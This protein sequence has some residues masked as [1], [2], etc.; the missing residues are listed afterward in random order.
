MAYS[1]TSSSRDEQAPIDALTFTRLSKGLNIRD[2]DW[3]SAMVELESIS[4]AEL[5]ERLAADYPSDLLVPSAYDKADRSRRPER[6]FVSLFARRNLIEAL[7]DTQNEYNVVN[8]HLGLLTPEEWLS[9]EADAPDLSPIEVPKGSVVTAMI[10]DGIGIAHELFRAEPEKTRVEFCTVLPAPPNPGRGDASQGR[11]LDADEIDKYLREF[12]RSDLLDDDQFYSH[13]AQIDYRQGKFSPVSLR[14]SHGTHVMGLST[15]FAPELNDGTRPIICA[16]LP[17]RVVEDTSG[18]SL[19]PALCL[20]LHVL[21]KQASRFKYDGE[22]VPMVTNFSYGNFSGPHDGTSEVSR[23]FEQ[24]LS[25]DPE[26]TR[27]MTLPA[28][29]GNLAR[30]HAELQFDGKNA[31]GIT[32]DLRVLPDDRTASHVELWMPFSE[33]DPPPDYVSVTVT[34][35][36]GP[37]S[38]TVKAQPGQ[39][40]TLLDE[41]GRVVATLLYTFEPAPTARGLI[42]LAIEPTASLYP[43]RALAPSGRWNIC[44]KPKDIAPDQIVQVWVRRDETLP[45]YRPGG[46]QSYFDNGD[47]VRFGPF[48]APLPVDPPDTPSPIRRAG[49]L[50]GF[51]CGPSPIVVAAY[52]KRNEIISYYSAAGPLTHTPMT[53]E[54][55]RNGPDVAAEGDESLV[56]WGVVSAGSR[57]GSYVRLNGTSVSAPR[58]ARKASDAITDWNGTAREWVA[59]AAKEDPFDLPPGTEPERMG[60]GGITIPIEWS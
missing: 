44:A 13:T 42:T 1:W 33:S 34:P 50:S 5:E 54:P 58:V 59:L 10:D 15:G 26:Q 56:L 38:L 9:F 45:G 41:L 17:P 30:A 43:G 46:R 47:Y 3:L 23:L 22:P 51:A 60:H 35:P 53:P 40:Q 11:V 27:W 29:N 39:H 7:N 48:G 12:T 16:V 25:S 37:E 55:S 21:G 28:G 49:T 2:S 36:F 14:R 6:Q 31:D 19:L 57:S 32:L 52:T 8:V 18:I 20:A 24:F 4:I